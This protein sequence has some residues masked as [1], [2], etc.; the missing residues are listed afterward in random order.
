MKFAIG[1]MTVGDILDRGLKIFWARL[2]TFYA[3][4]LIVMIPMLAYQMAM[5][6]FLV[7]GDSGPPSP[8][9][10]LAFMVG[11][12]GVVLIALILAPM[13][14]AASLHVIGQEFIG[15]RVGIADAFR[16]AFRRFL[17]LLG[18]S[19]LVGLILFAGLFMCGFPYFIF[20]T[21]YAFAG[22]VVVMEG[23]S[24]MDALNRSKDLGSDFFWRILG[25][26]ALLFV[27][28]LVAAFINNILN[29]L[30]QPL[31]VVPSDT[32]PRIVLRSYGLYVVAQVVNFLLA[33]AVQSY[34]AVCTTLLYFDLRIRKEGFDLELAAQQHKRGGAEPGDEAWPAQDRYDEGLRHGKEWP[35][36]GRP[37]EG[38]RPG[39]ER[40]EQFGT[41]EGIRPRDEGPG[42]I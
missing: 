3:I 21:W 28:S 9:M 36:E 34:S 42:T 4:N 32:G 14:A 19:I 6:A 29:Q 1:E 10:F 7:S 41:D 20:L 27:V 33:I 39:D 15:E 2:P 5:P 13:A 18:V 25:V 38:I 12:L 37:D 26:L 30:F 24:G 17:P 16:F 35:R 31:E 40:P 22:Q 11:T 8:E 23:R